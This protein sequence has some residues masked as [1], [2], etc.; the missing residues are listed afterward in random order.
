[1]ALALCGA[2]T[3]DDH[4]LIGRCLAQGDK[5][6]FAARFLDAKGLAWTG[7]LIERWSRP[8]TPP[9]PR[10]STPIDPAEGVPELP[11]ALRE[12]SQP[13]AATPSPKAAA[14]TVDARTN[15]AAPLPGLPGGPPMQDRLSPFRVVAGKSRRDS[16]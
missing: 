8:A 11:A 16:Q 6:R 2:S 9:T 12:A 14:R 3:P 1:V 5:S 4:K 13:A 10:N 15:G 7:E